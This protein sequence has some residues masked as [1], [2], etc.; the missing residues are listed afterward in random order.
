MN[1]VGKLLLDAP[2]RNVDSS[3]CK[4]TEPILGVT[5]AR[6]PCLQEKI[7]KARRP[8]TRNSHGLVA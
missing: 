2:F 8:R 7:I 4:V 6:T 1:V 3:G 5:T